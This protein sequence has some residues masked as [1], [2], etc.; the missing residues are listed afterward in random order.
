MGSDQNNGGERKTQ[1]NPQNFD[2]LER[3]SNQRSQREVIG[4]DI[5]KNEVWS[6]FFYNRAIFNSIEPIDKQQKRIVLDCVCRILG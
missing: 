5:F 6:K 2:I 1:R 4:K 3:E